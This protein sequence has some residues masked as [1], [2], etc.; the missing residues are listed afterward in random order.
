MR[1]V[2]VYNRSL[3][4]VHRCPRRSYRPLGTMRLSR[5][6]ESLP[7]AWDWCHG[8]GQR[9]Q[10]KVLGHQQ[11]GN[12]YLRK[13]FIRSTD[14]G[15]TR[16]KHKESTLGKLMSGWETRTARNVVIVATVNKLARISWAV[17]PSGENYHPM[18]KATRSFQ[19]DE[20]FSQK[21][22]EE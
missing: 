13:M 15:L 4:W 19:L 2:F 5:K 16:V 22:A 6:D 12:P 3:V 9:R 7:R 1:V 11:T 21:S 18:H 8:N 20:V 10:D 14:C 17:L